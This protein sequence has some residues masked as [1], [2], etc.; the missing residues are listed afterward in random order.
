MG[1]EI[2]LAGA[3]RNSA[4]SLGG[5]GSSKTSKLFSEHFLQHRPA[6]S[7]IRKPVR[8]PLRVMKFG[9]T[10]VGDASCIRKVVEIIQ[11][12]SRESNVV[13][14]VSAMSGVTN[15]LVEA[16]MRSEAGDRGAVAA[17]FEELRT[18]HLADAGAL[19]HSAVERKRIDRK[20]QEVFQEGDSL[21][22]G[23]MLLRELTL[24]VRD[25]ISSLGERLSAPLVAAALRDRGE[26]SEAIDAT[27]VVVTDSC[28]G[29]AEPLMDLTRDR[30]NSRLLPLLRQGIVPIVTGF[31]GAT[32]EGVVTTLGRNGSDY[33]AT[34][35]GAALDADEVIIWS[36]VDGVLTVDPRLV[37][38]VRLIPEISFR[39]A[40]ELAY[41]GAKVLHPKTLRPVMQSGTPLWIR[42][43]FAPER[44]GTKITPTGT[45]N[46]GQVKA[47]TAISD[48]TLIT[49]GGPGMLGVPDVLGRTFKTIEAVRANVLLISQ[50]SSQYDIR[51]V[52]SSSLAQRTVEAL[53]HEFAQDLAYEKVEHITLDPDVAIVAVVGQNMSR[54]SGIVGRTF[55]A[56]DRENVNIIAIAQG[57]SGCSISFLVAEKDMKSALVTTHREFQL[58]A[59]NSEVLA[60]SST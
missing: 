39:E 60:V 33:S 59:P 1:P 31:I 4:E 25:S 49:V 42:N 13:V 37:P 24:R 3:S 6:Q 12:A 23:T 50:S 2:Y 48:V 44:P 26:A 55:G 58:G 20:M 19:V 14:V 56:L 7:Q 5:Q 22:Q 27:E 18:R 41:F 29:A 28:H 16:A 36:D 21:C 54:L 46:G 30:C 35:L 17:I 53:R 52:V 57:S 40:T 51:L 32:A 34:I 9:G 8:K 11:A 15:K 47:L 38:G 43:T 45:P 10:S